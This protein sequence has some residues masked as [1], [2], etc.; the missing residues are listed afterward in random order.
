MKNIFITET[1]LTRQIV[2]QNFWTS[3][4]GIWETKPFQG[5]FLGAFF[6]SLSSKLE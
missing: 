4:L 1:S 3:S 5:R 2:G 6:G